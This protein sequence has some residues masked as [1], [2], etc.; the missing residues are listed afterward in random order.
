VNEVRQVKPFHLQ[1]FSSEGKVTSSE[2]PG[3]HN[4]SSVIQNVEKVKFG[5][6]K[7]HF[8]LNFSLYFD[9]YRIVMFSIGGEGLGTYQVGC[10][11]SNR[12]EL[13]TF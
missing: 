1:T 8:K 7:G 4:Y 2:I 3:C 11:I 6:K 5:I 13:L 10:T 9:A 12:S